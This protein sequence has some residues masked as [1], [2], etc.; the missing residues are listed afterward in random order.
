MGL[1]VQILGLAAMS[2]ADLGGEGRESASRLAETV[3]RAMW[4]RR[5]DVLSVEEALAAVEGVHTSGH[6]REKNSD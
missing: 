2:G 6:R 1:G 3:P 5:I 4:S